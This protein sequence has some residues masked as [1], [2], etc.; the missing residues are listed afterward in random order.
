MK[1]FLALL[2][3]VAVV[4]A[5]TYFLCYHQAMAPA[6]GVTSEGT[7][8]ELAWLQRE[9]ALEAKQYKRVVA[10]HRA[11]RPACADQCVRYTAAHRRL[12]ELLKRSARWSPEMD[13]VF[14]EQARVESECHASMLKYAYDVAACMSDEQGRRY[15]EMIK[16]QLLEG[17]PAGMFISSR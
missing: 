3:L 14:A 8:A 5:G 4:G 16:L 2:G 12:T 7:D 10:L 15:L 6:E 1:N 13:A 11:Y 17:D 9:F